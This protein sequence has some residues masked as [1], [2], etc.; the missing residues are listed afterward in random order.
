MK[1]Q[2]NQ[3]GR[4]FFL[5]RRP[6]GGTLPR[7]TIIIYSLLILT[8]AGL[9]ASCGG[10]VPD[11]YDTAIID[12]PPDSSSFTVC[13]R[14]EDGI[15]DTPHRIH[16]LDL[17]IYDADGAK[18]LLDYRRYDFL[19]DSVLLYGT[20]QERMM[21]AIANSCF[22][23]N[24]DALSRFDSIEMIVW[25]FEDDS[26]GTPVMSGTCEIAPGGRSSITLTP[27]MARVQLGEISNSM[28]GYL[29][30]ENPRLYLDNMNASAE[31][32]RTVGFR[33]SETVD[34]PP[35]T[36]LPYDIGIF[37]QNPGTQVF[38]YPNDTPGTIGTPATA[39]VLECEICGVTHN[40][41]TSIPSVA[42]NSTTRIDIIV[43]GPDSFE[44]K[45]Y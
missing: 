45:I 22:D 7:T 11:R 13:F 18:E 20:G 14:I 36:P 33:P 8:A 9:I 40:F 5:F 27:L 43:N 17:F 19:P 4:R 32:L 3:T 34:D 41:S 12:V 24:T 30:L 16:R 15:S 26:P 31:L 37:P 28:K 2:R 39:I 42:R 25:N 29:R 21:V 44:S 35:V 1:A 23:F 10:V 6:P 38:C